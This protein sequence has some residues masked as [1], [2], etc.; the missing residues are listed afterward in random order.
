MATSPTVEELRALGLWD[1]AAPDAVERWAL[2]EYLIGLGATVD[3]IREFASDLPVLGQVLA[4]RGG[5]ERLTRSELAARAGLPEAVIAQIN[6]A[7]GFAD[8]GP[9]DRVFTED[10]VDVFRTIKTAEVL[11][12]SDA[13]AHL[14]RLLGSTMA[15][16]AEAFVA[17]FLVNVRAPLGETD[18]LTRARANAEASTLIPSVVR[19][20]DVLLRQ[21]L[22]AARRPPDG[23]SADG[24]MQTLAVG[25]VDMVGSTALSQELTM[26]ELNAAI[27]AFEQ[28][29]ADIVTSHGGRVVKLIGDEVMFAFTDPR[30]ACETALRLTETFTEAAM[31]PPIRAG[32]AWG[33]VLS[34]DGD[35]YGPVVNLAA[36]VV[37]LARP[38]T[39]LVSEPLAAAVGDAYRAVPIPPRRLHGFEGRVPM[40]VL[41]RA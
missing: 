14:T 26:T 39:A 22:I 11:F 15:R 23:G 28:R 34:R 40:S 18:G 2:L 37:K 31:L 4:L 29:A 13:V 9:T 20:M 19:A 32:I 21:H 30:A 27:S 35:H 12:G 1:A 3:D 36:R 10:H 17:A 7:A 38:G 16:I 5:R 33:D 41:R 25:F 6:R 24:W 8:P